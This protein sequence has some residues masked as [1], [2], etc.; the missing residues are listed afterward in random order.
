MCQEVRQ[1]LAHSG[2]SVHNS[3]PSVFQVGAS[4]FLPAHPIPQSFHS[5]LCISPHWFGVY[6]P[7]YAISS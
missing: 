3:S 6:L 5:L 4:S 1:F 7:N 2:L